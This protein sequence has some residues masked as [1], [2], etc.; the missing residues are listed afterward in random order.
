MQ[1]V[2]IVKLGAIGDVIMA[3]PA[4]RTLYE[5]GAEIDWV[6]GVA[7]RPLLECY[8]WIR[9]IPVDDKLILKGGRREQLRSICRLWRL[10]AG[11]RYD[12]CAT[13]YY[14]R[15]YRIL[16]LPVRA[17]KKIF[18]SRDS[19]ETQL[20]AG[21]HHADEYARILLDKADSYQPESTSP[22]RPDRMP[23]VSAAPGASVRVALVPGG[24][25][26]MLRQQTLRQWPIELYAQLAR[27]LLARG[28]E[29]V[30]LGGPDD[31]WVRP[32]FAD[33]AIT[34]RIGELSLP[35]VISACD[36]CDGVV[37]HDTG[38]LHLAGLS[39]AVVVGLFGPTDPACFLPRRRYVTGITGGEGFACKPCYDGRNF[40]PCSNNGCMQQI[41]PELILAEMDALLALKGRET[42]SWNQAA[43]PAADAV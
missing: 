25:S 34:D 27:A 14:D 28:W 5:L 17:R 10:L 13:L 38:P 11:K 22:V 4:V 26:N 9:V 1:R 23:P 19:R 16:T 2:L 31:A 21:R 35:Q 15:R 18:L 39:H 20:I 41:K 42:S 3:I 6:C 33:M 40:A 43:I 7:V 29:V 36:A 24:A 8:S 12:L 30:L 32:Y 37:S